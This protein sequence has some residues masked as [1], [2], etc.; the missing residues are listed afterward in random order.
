MLTVTNNWKKTYPGAY[1][2]I[3]AMKN[4]ANPAQHSGL[5]R[6]KRELEADLRV[7]F[8]DRGELK[9]LQPIRAYQ[10][11][12]KG[13]NKTYHLLQQLESVIFKGKPIPTVSPLVESMFIEELRNLLLT[14]GHD[15]ESVEVPVTLDVA[16]G[17][18]Q[19]T[20]ING[21]DQIV[22]P[23]D[24]ILKDLKGVI[25]SILYG[26]DQRTRITSSTTSVLFT[27]YSVPGIGEK[28]VTQH[29]QGI[30]ANVKIV[31]PQ[32]FTDVLKVY[33]AD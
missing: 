29:L 13:F 33:G 12:Y 15:L 5:D 14:A 31:A 18:E 28:V 26:P 16:R 21:Q 22:K 25:S 6:V 3:L 20:L 10:N 2:G 32:A 30:E 4:V 1:F 17:D 7:L 27:V 11:Y 23:K 24:M 9:S 8:K 19:Y